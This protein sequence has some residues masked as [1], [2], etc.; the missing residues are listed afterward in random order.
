MNLK[1]VP[2]KMIR[3]KAKDW[4]LTEGQYRTDGKWLPIEGYIS[5]WLI[6][7]TEEAVAIS[8]QLFHRKGDEEHWESRWTV[9]IP[10]E[11]VVELEIL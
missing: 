10:K 6:S 11:T 1:E 5:G 7:E 2:Y 4:S 9:T 8:S 3:V